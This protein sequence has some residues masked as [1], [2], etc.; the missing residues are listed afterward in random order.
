MLRRTWRSNCSRG[1]PPDAAGFEITVDPSGALMI[2]AGRYYVDGLLVENGAAA[3]LDAS[4]PEP[5]PHLVYLDVWEEAIP[6]ADDP[7]LLEPA[8]G[9]PDTALRLQV[10]WQVRLEPTADGDQ[11]PCGRL[12]AADERATLA[13]RTQPGG[14]SGPENRLYRVE[15][16]AVDDDGNVS[17]KWSRDNASLVIRLDALRVPADDAKESAGWIALESGI[18]VALGRGA[19]RVGDYW[20]IPA[21]PAQPDVEWPDDPVPAERIEH[22]CCPLAIVEFDPRVQGWR[23]V[24]DLRRQFAPL[25]PAW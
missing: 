15:V 11:D 20:L 13:V 19:P 6:A 10:A 18:E 3:R 22:A 7:D 9:G 5:G 14:Y 16:H 2:G 17:L 23:V 25:T 8:L 4:Q 24:K 1:G 21:R 12:R